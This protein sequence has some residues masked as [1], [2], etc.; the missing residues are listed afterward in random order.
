[1]LIYI[2]SLV[3]SGPPYFDPEQELVMSRNAY[4]TSLRTFRGAH[5][6]RSPASVGRSGSNVN[7]EEAGSTAPHA[8]VDLGLEVVG[9]GV[10]AEVTRVD[11]ARAE[12]TALKRQRTVGCKPP[13]SV[14]VA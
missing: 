10:E 7:P 2:F 12:K 4:A 14:N 6:T 13:Q 9:A 11:P 5:R 1:M 3:L 8:E